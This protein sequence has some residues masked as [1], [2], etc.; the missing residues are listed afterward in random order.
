MLGEAAIIVSLPHSNVKCTTSFPKDFIRRAIVQTLPWM[1][2]Q[3]LF[4]PINLLLSQLMEV[5][6][7]G[8]ESSDQPVDLFHAAFLP[9]VVRHT[10]GREEKKTKDVS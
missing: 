6:A 3:Q 7:F 1:I 5:R 4:N 10:Y 9:T 2:V 8:E